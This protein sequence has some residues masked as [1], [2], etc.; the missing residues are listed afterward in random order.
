MSK[1]LI[2]F[3]QNARRGGN[4][5]FSQTDRKEYLMWLDTLI[6]DPP[7]FNR[8][9]VRTISRYINRSIGFY[10]HLTGICG[11]IG[12]VRIKYEGCMENLIFLL[13]FLMYKYYFYISKEYIENIY[14]KSLN[15]VR[16]CP[17]SP[18]KLI[19]YEI[20]TGLLEKIHFYLEYYFSK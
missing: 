17:K 6:Y 20:D 16:F 14:K 5:L 18:Q 1:E 10:L 15:L 8:R 3:L 4:M 11:Y 2:V 9:E 12:R 13:D 19:E 7:R